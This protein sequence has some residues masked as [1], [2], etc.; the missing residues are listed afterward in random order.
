[1]AIQ[2]GAF[3]ALGAS[4]MAFGSRME[5]FKGGWNSW[6]EGWRQSAMMEIQFK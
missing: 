3:S 6:I 5:S 2:Q 4:G 1:M